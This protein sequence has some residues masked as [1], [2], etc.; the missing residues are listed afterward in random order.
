MAQAQLPAK[1]AARP[2]IYNH[3][4]VM[5][6]APQ[7]EMGKVLCPT[8]RLRHANVIHTVL[9]S[10][11]VLE[12]CVL[13]ERIRWCRYL[14]YDPFAATAFAA[15]LNYRNAGE[16]PNASGFDLAPAKLCRQ[17]ADAVIWMLG[18]GGL[19]FLDS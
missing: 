12:Y 9:R 1:H 13:L 7:I 6:N 14:W 5:L 2:Y 10:Q 16:R 17:P 3:R 18:V 15:C 4:Q 11:L 8:I 19:Q